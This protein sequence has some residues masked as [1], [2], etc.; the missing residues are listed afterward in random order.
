MICLDTKATCLEHF[1]YPV[2]PCFKEWRFPHKN[3]PPLWNHGSFTSETRPKDFKQGNAST[4]VLLR[5][6]SCRVSDHQVGCEKAH[7]CPRSEAR[8]FLDNVM[9]S[10]RKEH[11]KPVLSAI[12]SPANVM[13]MRED[14]HTAFDQRQFVFVPKATG[15]EAS[16]LVTHVLNYSPELSKLYHNT[17]LHSI[18]GIA[19]EFLF[20]R[21]AWSVFPLLQNFL[22]DGVSKNLL[23]STGECRVLSSDECNSYLER[24][25][26]RSQSGTPSAKSSSDTALDSSEGDFGKKIIPRKRVRCVSSSPSASSA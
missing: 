10:Y 5:D 14:L 3:L 22:V 25:G 20:A 8:W 7:L 15:N 26:T 4:A 16:V 19:P 6:V 17:K 21:F 24:S 13:L 2:V 18:D 23:L 1:K 12:N 9:Q 11:S